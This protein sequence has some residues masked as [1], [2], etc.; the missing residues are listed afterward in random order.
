[1][2]RMQRADWKRSV[3]S[4]SDA[5]A[6][7][8]E[9]PA[10]ASSATQM[11]AL[12]RRWLQR[13]AERD[14]APRGANERLTRAARSAGERVDPLVQRRVE[15]ATGADLSS[16]RVHTGGAS[17]EAAASVEARAYTVGRDVHFAAGQ[18]QP[19]TRE[20]QRLLAHELVH[21]VQ[22][23][24]ASADVA[25][26]KLEVSQPGDDAEREA[27]ALADHI[28]DGRPAAP[29]SVQQAPTISRAPMLQ[30]QEAATGPVG[31][32]GSTEGD[33][34]EEQGPPAP[35]ENG[36]EPVVA[37]L[38]LNADVET[39]D[40][41]K[42]SLEDLAEAKV[43]HAWVS[44]RYNDPAKVPDHLPNPS[45]DLLKGGGTAM[46]FWPLIHRAEEWGVDGKAT[47]PEMRERM[48][49]GETPGAG[50]S[51]N[52]EHTGFS[53]NPFKSYVPGRVEEPDT[54][55]AAKG[56]MTYELTQ[57]QVDRL[58]GYVDSKRSAQYSLFFYNCTNFAVEAVQAAGH[59]PPDASAFGICMPNALYK[60]ILELKQQGDA[61]AMT[62]P[63]EPG[64]SESTGNDKKR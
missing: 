52:P 47:D 25:Q 18:Y 42:L 24:Q 53:L 55:H 28:V 23:G 40:R 5:D 2:R 30:R 59:A 13:K 32:A 17:A 64:E 35:E 12:Q 29:Q 57:K 46:G 14:G 38:E 21:T 11:R 63:L 19:H 37:K 58:M 7:T 43:G 61:D 1:M 45:H 26:H 50:A 41:T 49:K 16:V 60:S 8:D 3:P 54:A 48:D 6:A 62:T 15:Q 27:D 51:P 33:G 36:G 31:P 34:I 22:Q 10:S 9:A 4:A 39:A 56:L 44:L 20:G